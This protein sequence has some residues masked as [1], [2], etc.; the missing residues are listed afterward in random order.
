MSN[1][2]AKSVDLVNQLPGAAATPEAVFELLHD[3]MHLYRGERQ[4]AIAAGGQ[5]IT[6]LEAKVL[7]FFHRHPGATLSDLA[8]HAGRDKSQL[9]RLIAGLRERGL[10]EATPDE[11]DRRNLRLHPTASAS[12]IHQAMRQQG[13]RVARAALSSL[14]AAERAQ[15]VAS[16]AKLATGL[17]K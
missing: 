9:A 8:A 16:L 1:I 6:H 15:L 10:L 12:E 7:G 11:A 13:T 3:V 2:M 17:R 14:D 4:R 5:E